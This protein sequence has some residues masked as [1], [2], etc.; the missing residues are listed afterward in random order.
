MTIMVLRKD[1]DGTIRTKITVRSPS[2]HGISSHYV[3]PGGHM[4]G[5]P[6]T[7]W[8]K[9]TPGPVSLKGKRLKR[10][11]V[12]DPKLIEWLEAQQKSS[13]L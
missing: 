5:I 10:E 4:F 2:M 8:D 6:Y 7:T 11:L 13:E 3:S 1:P 9:F 12:I